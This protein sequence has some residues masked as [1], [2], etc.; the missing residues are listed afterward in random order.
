MDCPLGGASTGICTNLRRDRF[1]INRPRRYSKD[2]FELARPINDL[3]RLTDIPSGSASQRRWWTQAPC[4]LNIF[5][6]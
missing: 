4:V 5:T 6:A 3:C 2:R 1:Q